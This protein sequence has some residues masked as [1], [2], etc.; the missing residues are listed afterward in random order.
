MRLKNYIVSIHTYILSHKSHT[1]NQ[2][3]LLLQSG[4]IVQ[5]WKCLCSLYLAPH[6]LFPAQLAFHA[7]LFSTPVPSPQ[8]SPSCSRSLDYQCQSSAW[9]PSAHRVAWRDGGCLRRLRGGRGVSNCDRR[10][11]DIRWLNADE[12]KSRATLMSIATR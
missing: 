12:G 4:H 10:S 3:M 9:V 11:R 7:P 6:F 8:P 1:P 2:P 5:Q